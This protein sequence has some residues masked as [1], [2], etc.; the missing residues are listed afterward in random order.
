MFLVHHAQSEQ[1]NLDE[2]SSKGDAIRETYGS[3]PGIVVGP[4]SWV[5]CAIIP[6]DLGRLAIL[7]RNGEV[8]AINRSQSPLPQLD[9]AITKSAKFGLTAAVSHLLG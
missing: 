3:V 6:V 5:Q 9:E 7:V 1:A 8:L 2:A 4:R